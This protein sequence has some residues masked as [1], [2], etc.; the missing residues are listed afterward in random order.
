MAQEKLRHAKR[1]RKQICRTDVDGEGHA[2]ATKPERNG[3]S[4]NG[5]LI[6]DARASA[7]LAFAGISGNNIVIT[8]K[9]GRMREG[10]KT[11]FAKMLRT[12]MT[13]AEKKLWSYLRANRFEGIKF[14]RQKPIGRYIVDFCCSRAK[15]IVE[16]DGGQ[17]ELQREYDAGRTAFLNS[18]GYRV[19]RFSDTD[20][21]KNTVGVL[22][23]IRIT[24]S[25]AL[26]RAHAQGRG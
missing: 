24:L 14:V 25:L 3:I 19:V 17:H 20:A 10:Q 8:P 6:R 11:E 7:S 26:P 22:E 2:A 18:K 13:D 21:L 5:V 12:G 15:V 9:R 1:T 4:F 23:Q 16:L